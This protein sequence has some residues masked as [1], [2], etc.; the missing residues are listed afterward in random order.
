M[1]SLT[2]SISLHSEMV[3]VSAHLKDIRQLQQRFL[4]SL[5][6]DFSYCTLQAQDSKNT[7][8]YHRDSSWWSVTQNDSEHL[9]TIFPGHRPCWYF[10]RKERDQACQNT[11]YIFKHSGCHDVFVILRC[12]THSTTTS[13]RMI[14][15]RDAGIR[16]GLDA[17]THLS[18]WGATCGMRVP[19][20]SGV[21]SNHFIECYS[22]FSTKGQHRHHSWYHELE[23]P[24]TPAK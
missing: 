8:I 1:R 5:L 12:Q 4:L 10:W 15:S 24:Y 20:Y 9:W 18:P 11:E 16:R 23:L 14:C 17:I 7:I 21:P 6:R 13:R 19:W 3:S 2:V 22:L